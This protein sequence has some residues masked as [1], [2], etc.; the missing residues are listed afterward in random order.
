MKD[1]IP[2]KRMSGSDDE[3]DHFE[4]KNSKTN[5]HWSSS[6]DDEI[7]YG[8]RLKMEDCKRISSYSS[9]RYAEAHGK[10]NYESLLIGTA[11]TSMKSTRLRISY[12][13]NLINNEI[14]FILVIYED[15]K[16]LIGDVYKPSARCNLMK[17]IAEYTEFKDSKNSQDGD[18]HDVSTFM[19]RIVT[20]AAN[21]VTTPLSGRMSPCEEGITPIIEDEDNDTWT[22][23]IECT[24]PIRRMTKVSSIGAMTTIPEDTQ[25]IAN[26]IG[27]FDGLNNADVSLD[28]SMAQ[29]RTP[30]KLR[31]SPLISPV[32]KPRSTSCKRTTSPLKE[33]TPKRSAARSLRL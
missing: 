16:M 30:T 21:V 24:T 13:R 17:K 26:N 5:S 11:S 29:L 9:I 14:Q 15:M 7:D 6:D 25:I 22:T 1:S 31:P 10:V 20:N 19:G 32:R 12:R 18:G 23:K 27:L 8:K 28:Y 33:P 3:I 4:N 2:L